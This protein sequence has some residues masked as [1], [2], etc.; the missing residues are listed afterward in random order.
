[1]REVSARLV[2]RNDFRLIMLNS[3]QAYKKIL[4]IESNK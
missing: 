2:T 3:K 1:M 4:E